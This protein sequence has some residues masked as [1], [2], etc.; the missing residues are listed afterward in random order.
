MKYHFANIKKES[1]TLCKLV[2][3]DV[4]Q[5][6]RELISKKDAAKEKKASDKAIRRSE[7]TL[8]A[9]D[10]GAA[11]EDDILGGV[12]GGSDI[13]LLS[14]KGKSKG[15]TYGAMDK[16]CIKTP[17]EVVAA[18]KEKGLSAKLQSKLSTQR[19]EERRIRA[20]EYICQF[21]YEAGIAHNT[22]LLP[23]FENMLEAIGTFGS[24]MTGPTPYEMGGPYLKKSKK[25]VE[26]GFAGHKDAWNLTGCTIM[27]DAWTDKRGRGVMNLV[28]H[29]AYGVVFL[30]SVDCSD[31]RKDG[32]MIFELV[33]GCV[34]EIGEKNVIQIV[35]DNASV[36]ISAAA[37]MKVKCPNLFWNGCAAHT[38]D[39]MLED[40]GKLPRVEQTIVRARAVTVFLYAHTRV[41]ALMRKFL[42]KYLVRSGI[43]RFATAYL[44]LK[45]LQDNKKELQKLFRSDELND[46]DHLKK[47]KGKNAAKTIRSKTFWK[48]VDVAVNFF[49]P[50]ANVLRRMDSDVPAMG[51][52]YGCML[53]A[54]IEISARFD[55]EKS[56]FLEVWDII[57]KRW[58]NKLKT[59][60][61][62]AGYYLNPYY[63][64]PNKRAIELDGT[65]KEGLII[66]ISKMI[67]DPIEQGE[68][69]DDIDNYNKEIG[70]FR[71]DIAVRQW[72]NKKFDPAKWWMNHGTSAGKLRVLAAR[73]LG[74]TC[75]SSACERNWSVFDQV[76]TK[77]RNRL[78]HDKMS[79]LVFIKFNTKLTDKKLKTIKDPIEKHVVDVLEDDDNE[80]VT[81]VVPNANDEQSE[82]EEQEEE[83]PYASGQAGPSTSTTNPIL[84]RKRGIH[85]KK[86]K[87][88]IPVTPHE[89]LLSASSASESDDDD[90][91]NDDNDMTSGSDM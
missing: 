75:S 62:R 82:G 86:K 14:G 89:D 2:P 85:A 19:R 88:M 73:I 27:T 55:N 68:I 84:K 64:Y 30:K 91:D 37:M 46:M 7:V 78:L 18:R 23:S 38:I 80:W 20:C 9:N 32:K 61:H 45:S 39:L 29:S 58:D 51:F 10:D 48:A 77:R 1:C 3:A 28:V 65:F 54:K 16:F 63:Y 81:G 4:K 33:D 52:L 83:L 31:V 13:L 56:R 43:T 26:E 50:M 66:C 25:K 47:A 67:D 69:T 36:N 79:D 15:S 5:E 60:L 8:D 70:S 11:D 35:T 49:E 74:L 87:K 34:E 44:N 12:G 72:R 17:E 24:D 57:D 76:H 90:V 53:D 71:R 42:G 22:V 41:L 21:F 59:A 6:M 40:I